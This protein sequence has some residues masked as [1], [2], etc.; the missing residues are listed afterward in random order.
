MLSMLGQFAERTRSEKREGKKRI[1]EKKI[2]KVVRGALTVAQL[3]QLCQLPRC[4]RHLH[5]VLD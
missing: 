5:L 2:I 4:V 1:E 3:S